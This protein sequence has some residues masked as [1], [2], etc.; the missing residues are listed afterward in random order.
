MLALLIGIIA[1]M[2]GIGGGVFIVPALKLLP[3]STKFTLDIAGGTSLA[4]IFFKALSSSSSYARQ[5][6]IDYKVGLLLATATI[7]GA[8]LGRYLAEIV[9]EEL[10][11]LIFAMFL[12]YAASRMI[13][14]YSLGNF[15]LQINPRRGWRRRLIDSYGKTFEYIVDIKLGLP[16]SFLAG[17]SSGLLGIGG[18][19]LMV[20]I[21]H[22]ALSFPIHLAVATSVFIMVFTSISG[23]AV[24]VYYERVEFSYAFLLIFG[25][26]AGAQIGA[27]VSKHV[28][29]KNLRRIFGLILVFV[30]LRMIL[31]FLVWI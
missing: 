15:K 28:S 23:F 2:L 31:E 17:V 12:L 8:A 10:L 14:N 9:P 11:V 18:G 1:A 7:P 27:Y 13:F 3:L 21:L 26:I 30:S 5:K 24:A 6:R 19:A 16:L 22:F 29:S 20:P 25:V 4:M